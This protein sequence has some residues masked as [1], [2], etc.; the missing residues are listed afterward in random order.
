MFGWELK[1]EMNIKKNPN[2]VNFKLWKK[3]LEMV[4]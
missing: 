3:L 4:K 2:G 1:L